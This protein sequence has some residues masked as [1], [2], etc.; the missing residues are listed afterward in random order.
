MPIIKLSYQGELT[1]SGLVF[2]NRKKFDSEM[3]DARKS[4]W[5]YVLV[6]VEKWKKKKSWQQAKYL[7]GVVYPM[8]V[9]GLNELGFED[10]G[11][12]EQGGKILVDVDT[13]HEYMK[14]RFST[15][16]IKVV[17]PISG[18]VI[19]MNKTTKSMS[20]VQYMAFVESI[21]KFASEFLGINIPDPDP[22][23]DQ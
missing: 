19:K 23:W 7:F 9:H 1:E 6:T 17:S 2:K 16:Y 14:E 4:K 20:T 18:E 8:V 3:Q 22:M 21:R 5:K 15:E 11:E 10:L 12:D 13:V